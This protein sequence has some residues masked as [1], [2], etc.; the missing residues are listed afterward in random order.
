[1]LIIGY[2]A[3]TSRARAPGRAAWIRITVIGLLAALYQSCY[4]IAV[5]LTS[6]PLATLITIGAA[7]VIVLGAERLT[8]RPRPGSRWSPRAWP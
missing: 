8:G 7:P 3:V 1:M 4:F 2:L 6:V 5:S